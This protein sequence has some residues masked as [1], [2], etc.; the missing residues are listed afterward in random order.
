MSNSPSAGTSLVLAGRE[1]LYVERA[2]R[3]PLTML[4]NRIDTSSG[5]GPRQ[6]TAVPSFGCPKNLSR[7]SKPCSSSGRTWSLPFGTCANSSRKAFDA[8]ERPPYTRVHSSERLR[9]ARTMASQNWRDGDPTRDED[10]PLS[11]NQLKVVPWSSRRYDVVLAD[12]GMYPFR[13]PV[14]MPSW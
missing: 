13:S 2:L 6:Y 1:T 4:L 5:P 10:V 7:S 14:D 9:A 3:P 12:T 8:R 11:P